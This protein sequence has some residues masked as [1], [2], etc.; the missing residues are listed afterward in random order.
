MQ[1]PIVFW[2]IKADYYQR[3]VELLFNEYIDTLFPK[4]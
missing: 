4:I 3:T 2:F 1:F